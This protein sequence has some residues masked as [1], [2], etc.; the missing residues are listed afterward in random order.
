MRTINT[1]PITIRLLRPGL[2]ASKDD[3]VKIYQQDPAVDMY[4][5]TYIDQQAD[6]DSGTIR[7][8]SVVYMNGE[9]MQTYIESLFTLLTRDIEPFNKFQLVAPGF[10]CILLTVDELKKAK[11]R[12]A[13]LN[14]LPMLTN[15]WKA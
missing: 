12:E 9:Q 6:S 10:P 2:D 14:V 11:T 7:H 15:F 3:I 5:V 1:L 4:K 8:D 13:I